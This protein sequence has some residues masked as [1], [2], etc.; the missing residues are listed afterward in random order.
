MDINRVVAGIDFGPDTESVIAYS[1]LFAKG[2]GASLNLLHVMDFLVTPPAYVAP[3]IEEEKKIIEKQFGLLVKTI[4]AE[5]IKPETE[6]LLGRLQESFETAIIRYSA[7]MLVLGFKPHILRRSSAE[8]LIKGLRMPMLVVRG[9]TARKARVGSVK[10]KK[11]V[12]PVDF[13]EASKKAVKAAK[14][15]SDVFAAEL[16]L[17]H[18]MPS[19]VMKEKMKSLKDKDS[20][21]IRKDMLDQA[22]ADLDEFMGK[23]GME[24]SGTIYEGEPYEEI[25]RASSSSGCDL[26]VMAARGL[27]YIKEMLV[28][29]VTDAVLR[30]SPCPVLVIH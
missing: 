9:E 17:I 22:K 4:E 23:T 12:C 24:N 20:D 8:K 21:R 29:S 14:E 5:G 10:I 27:S 26:I 30:S 25:I 6:V 28:G 18:V 7:D 2:T 1:L 11:I 13:S 16:D 15:L 3:Y 19:H